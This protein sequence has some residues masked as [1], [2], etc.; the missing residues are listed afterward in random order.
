[1]RYTESIMNIEVIHAFILLLT[2]G[3]AFFYGKSDLAQ[4]DLQITAVLFI[5][6]F[7]A[8]KFFAQS[9]RSR[10]LES[11][12]FTFIII[13]IIISTGDVQSPFYFLIYFLLFSLSLIL[14]PIISITT[15]VGLIIFFLMTMPPNQ[16]LTGLMPIFSLAFL[17]PF[18]L[19][20]GQ[21]FLKN[22]ELKDK[23]TSLQKDTFLFLSLML[24]NH[25]KA[26]RES[27]LNFMGDH[28][29]HEIGRHAHEMEKLIER[30]EK[31][32]N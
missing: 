16:D 32:Q 18:A 23:T 13:S 4:Y 10:L 8:R 6:F 12:M 24:K 5:V 9:N 2:I 30:Y 27:V 26:I 7:I 29:L 21:E 15:T 3:L 1:M 19:L 20:L 14:E 22:R 25:V 31:E 28:D 11:V 17:T